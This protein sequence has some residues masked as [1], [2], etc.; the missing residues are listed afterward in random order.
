MIAT[1]TDRSYDVDTSGAIFTSDVTTVFNDDGSVLAVSLPHRT[2]Y[3]PGS[4][5]DDNSDAKLVEMAS[6]FHTPAAIAAY[7]D[8]Q[9]V[10]IDGTIEAKETP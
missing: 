3:P 9:K 5:A 7:Q 8:A 10:A 1:K 4:V 2:P 6:T